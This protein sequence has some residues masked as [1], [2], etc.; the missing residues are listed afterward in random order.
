[1]NTLD[2]VLTN[3]HSFCEPSAATSHPP[4]GL[5]DHCVITLYPKRRE[6]NPT[7]KKVI[8]K[9]DTRPSRKQMFGN[10][11]SQ[12]DWHL[13]DRPLSSSSEKMNCS[14]E[15]SLQV[16]TTSCLKKQSFSIVTTHRGLLK[17]SNA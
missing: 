3:R 5:S 4:F 9:R 16:K 11:L 17:I 1:M 12:I 6:R 10:Y 15:L 7:T 13:L 8:Y 2:F 14:L